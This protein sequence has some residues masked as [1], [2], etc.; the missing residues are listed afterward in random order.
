MRHFTQRWEEEAQSAQSRECEDAGDLRETYLISPARSQPDTA[1][2]GRSGPGTLPGT[3]R[4]KQ[5]KQF[6][7]NSAFSVS[8]REIP[9]CVK[10]L[11][12]ERTRHSD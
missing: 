1:V 4:E 7:A 6:S 8:L 11:V 9:V 10:G 5:V 12:H 2:P 3:D